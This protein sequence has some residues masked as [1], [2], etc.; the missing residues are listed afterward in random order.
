MGAGATFFSET[1]AAKGDVEIIVEDEYFFRGDFVKRHRGGDGFARQIHVGGGKQEQDLL[2]GQTARDGEAVKL[3]FLLGVFHPFDDVFAS[4]KSNIVAGVGIFCAGIPKAYDE[5]EICHTENYGMCGCEWSMI[6]RM[7]SH[8]QQYKSQLL[9]R[10]VRVRQSLPLM[11]TALLFLAFGLS[12]CLEYAVQWAMRGPLWHGIVVVLAA[13]FLVWGGQFLLQLFALSKRFPKPEAD[14]AQ[15]KQDKPPLA[16]PFDVLAGHHCAVLVSFD[17]RPPKTYLIPNVLRIIPGGVETATDGTPGLVEKT[18]GQLRRKGY[19]IQVLKPE[20][21][22]SGGY[23]PLMG[24]P[25][26]DAIRIQ[27]FDMVFVNWN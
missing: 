10:L 11:V 5:M 24:N 7:T 1:E 21:K 9:G 8:F 15:P 20:G 14:A 6:R 13:V 27:P 3:V 23:A 12:L 17:D 18:V 25:K 4:H 2:C 22:V 16:F 26:R 19:P